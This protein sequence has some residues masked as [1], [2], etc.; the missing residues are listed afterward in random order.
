MAEPFERQ[1]GL[2]AEA[3]AD[4]EAKRF[5]D[6]LASF[7]H[8]RKL[9]ED[10]GE[11]ET[12]TFFKLV[13][14]VFSMYFQMGGGPPFGPLMNG[15]SGRTLLPEDLTE[16]ELGLLEKLA[17]VSENP[18]VV[19]RICDIIW[20][21][22]RDYQYA[23]RAVTA[24]LASLD[25]DTGEATW[26]PKSE[27]L[28]RAAQIALELGPKAAERDKVKN[29]LTELFEE[30]RKTC[31]AADWGYWP[32]AIL[33]IVIECRLADNWEE[34]GDKAV[35][36][37]KGFP[38]APGCDEPRAYLDQADKCYTLANKPDKA[39]A[40]RLAIAKHWEDEAQFFQAKDGGAFI[41]ADRLEKAIHAYR[42][43]GERAKA[44]DL[45]HKFKQK[46][47]EAISQMKSV[48]T[49]IDVTDIIKRAEEAMTGKNGM[50][51]IKTFA[52]LY[53]PLSYDHEE[54]T[55]KDILQKHPVQA[56]FQ[57][58]VMRE[59]GNVS[60]KVPGML[61]RYD[62]R[63]KAQI[64]S[65]YN[66]GQQ[67]VAGT[68]LKTAV[69]ILLKSDGTWKN[70]VAELL[71]QSAFVP[72]DRIPI[73]Q[74]AIIAGFEGDLALFTHFIIP[75]FENSVRAIYAING[76]KTTSVLS[77]G[78]QREKDLNELLYD[79]NAETVFTKNVLW[80][81]RSLLIE[82]SGP[83]MRN[84]LCHGLMSPDTMQGQHALFL[85]WLTLRLIFGFKKQ[86][87]QNA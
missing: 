20:I 18:E 53:A 4:V 3:V 62:E 16:D 49:R 78:T 1:S 77:D 50:E 2:F 10:S 65:Q 56:I 25:T 58:S 7:Q 35:E 47:K 39:R 6:L 51:A 43:A 52:S 15:P 5:P 87:P 67:L 48:E 14:G 82:Q 37:A 54:Q 60:E 42:A 17:G 85:L 55:A 80:E 59:E 68:A 46:N 19:A 79:S 45:I 9:A 21:R 73:Y 29:K 83:N 86:P 30:G 69:A 31:Y 75:Q 38:L 61:E 57:Q 64:L 44:E 23:K 40:A 11:T 26:V 24:Y 66:Q 33:D 32:K 8:R 81:M 28:K 12:V 71:S 70:A 34:L 76:H 41:V 27:W 36:T 84:R 63:L 72:E 22:K 74:R 13:W